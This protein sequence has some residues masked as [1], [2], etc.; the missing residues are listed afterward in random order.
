MRRRSGWVR[1]R[2]A[3]LVVGAAVALTACAGTGYHYVKNSSDKTYFKVPD[4]WKL[5]NED[6]VLD[7]ALHTHP[8]VVGEN[9]TKAS[10][11]YDPCVEPFAGS[12][13]PPAP[14]PSSP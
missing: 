14:G 10:P 1:S 8:Q 6:S 7:A 5:Y 13:P 12:L 2:V 11:T 4:S 3:A 9:G